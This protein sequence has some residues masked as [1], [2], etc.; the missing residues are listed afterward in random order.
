MT[1]REKYDFLRR[2]KMEKNENGVDFTELEQALPPVVFRNWPKWRD[3]LPIAPRTV[4]NED[5][6]GTGPTG[7]VMVG[8]VCGYYRANF[9]QWLRERSKVIS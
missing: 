3:I 9:V 1:R 2:F 6:K 4:A 8:R 5:S 7:K